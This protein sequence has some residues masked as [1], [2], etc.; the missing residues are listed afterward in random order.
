MSKIEGGTIKERLARLETLMCNH[1]A[2]HEKYSMWMIRVL[3]SL[4]VAF[5]LWVLPGT[6]Q[7]ISGLISR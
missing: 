5:I 7:F 6:I 4:T 1:L 2:H 3:A